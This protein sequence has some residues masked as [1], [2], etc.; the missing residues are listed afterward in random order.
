MKVR[1]FTLFLNPPPPNAFRC[2]RN[3]INVCDNS[4]A[5]GS[6][7]TRTHAANEEAPA[8]EVHAPARGKNVDALSES[9]AKNT[10]PAFYLLNTIDDGVGDRMWAKVGYITATGQS[11]LKNVLWPGQ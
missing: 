3:Q 1:Y 6:A 7:G 9:S 4:T 2:L 10:G 5:P 11:D 8:Q